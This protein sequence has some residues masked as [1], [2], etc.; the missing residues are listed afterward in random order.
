MLGLEHIE[1]FQPRY[2]MKSPRE[3]VDRE[4]MRSKIEVWSLPMFRRQRNWGRVATKVFLEIHQGSYYFCHGHMSR[5]FLPSNTGMIVGWSSNPEWVWLQTRPYCLR[6]GGEYSRD[7]LTTIPVLPDL[8]SLSSSA[9]TLVLHVAGALQFCLEL[10]SAPC[11]QKES[12]CWVLC[13]KWP[14]WFV[15][16]VCGSYSS[17]EIWRINKVSIYLYYCGRDPLAFT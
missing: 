12:E 2:Q 11:T 8:F 16:L 10:S 13:I 5:A 1:I 3:C 6:A 4:N 17:Q 14:H 15:F 7:C 9:S